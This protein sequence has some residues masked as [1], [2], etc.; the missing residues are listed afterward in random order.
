MAFDQASISKN[1]SRWHAQSTEP[2]LVLQDNSHGTSYLTFE[3]DANSSRFKFL[4]GGWH[5]SPNI[6]GE[7]FFV[8]S[9]LAELDQS[10]EFFHDAKSNQLWLGVNSS[11]VPQPG[12]RVE[13]WAAQVETLINITGTAKKPVRDVSIKGITI[14]HTQVDWGVGP[15]GTSAHHPWEELSNGDHATPRRGTVLVE[16]AEDTVV[17]GVRFEQ[18]GGTAVVISRHTRNVSVTNNVIVAPG[19]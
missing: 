4:S 11:A 12:Q 5:V 15:D 9:V 19:E 1:M 8:D 16:G 10:G 13:L 3:I 2:I 7:S 18:V 14:A 17:S 6:G